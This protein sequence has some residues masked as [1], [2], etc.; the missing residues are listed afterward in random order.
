MTD[1]L[2][3]IDLEDRD[4]LKA[5]LGGGLPRGSIV[6]VE[7]P[8]G[9]GKSVLSQ[10]FAHGCCE[11]GH[12]VTVLSTEQSL[13]GFLEQMDS[14]EYD[15]A[16]HLLDDRLLY[17]YAPLKSPGATPMGGGDRPRR[18]SYLAQ[19]MA[20]ERMWA[21]ELVVID[22]FD[23]IL[24]KDPTFEA[25]VRG[26]A[27]RQAALEIISFFREVA[28]AG[29]T[30]VLTV[31]QTAV[32]DDGLRPFRSIAD[33]Y[34]SLEIIEVGN[35]QRRQLAV[36]RFAGKGERVGKTIGYSIRPDTGVVIES[37]SVA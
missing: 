26:D 36:N 24:R 32:D 18:Q 14:F 25:L 15:V 30:V 29:K 34:F 27:G 16:G 4:R 10:R 1:G 3:S 33:V 21:S 37:R 11:A 12:S 9:A 31:D 2:Y 20:A 6:L 17:L 35:E 23:A 13:G 28:A 19:L 7:G 8:Y 5:E 22:T